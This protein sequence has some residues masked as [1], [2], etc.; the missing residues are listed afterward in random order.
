MIAFCSTMLCC[1]SYRLDWFRLHLQPPGF[2]SAFRAQV[3]RGMARCGSGASEA[4]ESVL[5]S[6]LDL[7]ST[8]DTVCLVL[9]CI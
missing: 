6:R 1:F 7:D 2:R 3:V 9:C 8:G 5:R 4:A